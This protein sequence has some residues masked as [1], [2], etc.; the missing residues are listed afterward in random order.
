MFNHT[1]WFK[2]R[3]YG[4]WGLTPSC[5]QGWAYIAVIALPVI[6]IPMLN[7]PGQTGTWLMLGWGGLFALDFIYI[8]VTLK[9]DERETLHE[10]L[11]ERN[12]MWFVI[13]ALAVGLAYQVA[14]GAIKQ[15]MTNID[16]VI[17]VALAGATIVKAATH[18]YLR[19]K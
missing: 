5:W 19:D 12:A 8:W 3:K 6:F 13:A 17:L 18:L 9:K 2:M 11:A 14:A 7:L 10:A 1:R 16:P 4:G 15:D